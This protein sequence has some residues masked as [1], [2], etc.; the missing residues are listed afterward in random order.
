MS[1]VYERIEKIASELMNT[2]NGYI[3]S[4]SLDEY[5][6]KYIEILNLG[7]EAIS[8]MKKQEYKNWDVWYIDEWYILRKL[9][10]EFLRK[11]F[12]SLAYFKEQRHPDS[13]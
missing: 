12:E 1:K 9:L 8:Y 11:E 4:R 13:M 3:G 2:H 6:N 10:E 7:I 5:I